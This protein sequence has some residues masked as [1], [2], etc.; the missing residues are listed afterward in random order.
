M[1]RTDLLYKALSAGAQDLRRNAALL[2]KINVFPV[3]DGDTGANM[4]MTVEA[5]LE[6]VRDGRNVQ[7]AILMGARGNSGVILA[8]FLVG[9]LDS[10]EEEPAPDGIG[11]AFSRARDLAYGAVSDPVEGTMLTVM[12]A[13][14]EH[15]R[16][17]PALTLEAHAELEKVLAKAVAKTPSLMPRLKQAG[18]VDSGALGFHVFA[19]GLTLFAA[20][21]DDPDA[22]DRAIEARASGRTSAPIGEVSDVIDPSFAKA[23]VDESRLR[24]CMDVIVETPSAPPA[25]WLARFEELGAS[26]DAVARGNLLKIHVHCDRP[27][28]IEA[29][30]SS[31]GT[32]LRAEAE[33]MT[34]Q[35]VKALPG[36]AKE[37]KSSKTVRVISDSSMSLPEDQLAALRI[38]RLENYVNVHGRMVRDMDLDRP[39][40]FGRMREGAT[41]T[42]AQT[43]AEEVRRFLDRQL[44]APGMALYMAVG[45]PYTGTQELVRKVASVHPLR[46]RLIIMDC[47]AA[48]GQQGLAVLATARRAASD[49]S[50]EELVEYARAQTRGCKEYLVIDNLK[51][52]SRTGRIGKIAATFAGALGLRPIVGH[53]GDGAITYA[54]VRS[55]DAAL[56]DISQRVERHPGEGHLLIMVEHTDNEDWAAKV[57]EHL[58][59]T[60][61]PTPEVFLSPLSSTAS[62]H[63]GPGTWGVAVTRI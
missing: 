63:M 19:C 46:H 16:E 9:L 61:T 5:A 29:A 57:A 24:Y 2:D 40:L 26:V 47:R 27:D 53:G 21:L 13:L 42:T 48:S 60:I 20:G 58:R 4:T 34:A 17:E 1:S 50:P 10:L 51:Y 25:D 54:K 6:A 33:D 43:S 62:V 38:G 56:K 15:L 39:R 14:A 11:R 32:V 52:L 49:P 45:K 59:S 35:L 37:H 18:V 44:D 36:A 55:H 8:Q 23:E 12:T 3:V 28:E 30:A 31:L 22:A 7:E 41:Y